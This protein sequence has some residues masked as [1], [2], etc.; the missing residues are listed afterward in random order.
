MPQTLKSL[1][2]PLRYPGGKSRALTNLFR[3]LPDLSQATEYREPFIGGGSVAIEVGKRYPKLNIWV[4]DLYEPL[5]NFWCELR[6]HGQEMRDQLVQLKYRHCEPASARVLFEQS[7]DYLNGTQSDTSNL[8]R[9]VAFYVVNKCS[10]SGLTESSSFSKQAS[11]SNFSMRGIDKLPDYS[12]MIKDWKITN[13]SYEELL[14]D[15][16]SVFTY[17]DP[18][19]DIRDNLYGRR[20]NMHKSFCHDTFA[21]DCDRFVGPQCVSY[22]SS[23]LVKERF[24]GWTVGE[25]AHTYTMRSV[26][27][28]NTDQASRKELILAN[29]EV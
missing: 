21:N 7:K 12:L 11:E 27:S 10:F 3:F 9:A 16:R 23:Q 8:S 15:D 25:F 29:Y 18:P 4:N 24:Q 28:Y 19:Y 13:L 6:D 5:Y 17:L 26:G 1:K 22:N 20:G 2:T 14:T